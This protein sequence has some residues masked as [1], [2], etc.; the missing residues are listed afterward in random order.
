MAFVSEFERHEKDRPKIHKPVRCTYS[1][2]RAGNK[3][4]IILETYGSADREFQDK[5]SQSIQLDEQGAAKL[6][7][8]LR[9]E[10]PNLR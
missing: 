8:I 4:Y 2:F 1:S 9:R 10:F 6:I 5:V 7:E 3:P